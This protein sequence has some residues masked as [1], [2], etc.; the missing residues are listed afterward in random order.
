MTAINA[1]NFLLIIYHVGLRFVNPFIQ[2]YDDDVMSVSVT[3]NFLNKNSPACDAACRQILRPRVAV[4]ERPNLYFNHFRDPRP[5]VLK[6][7]LHPAACSWPGPA[8]TH[9]V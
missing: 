4:S 1:S 6:I 5:I 9:S 8:W 3:L 2:I 7:V